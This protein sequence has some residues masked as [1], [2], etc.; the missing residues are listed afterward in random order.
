MTD[1]P[2]N[3]NIQRIKWLLL[4][5]SLVTIVYLVLAA[6][7][8]HLSGAWRQYQMTYR[9]ALV[10][11]ADDAASQRSAED[12]AIGFQQIFLPQLDRID[13]C[14][15]CHIAIDDPKQVDAPQPL[16]AHSGEIL[17][18]HSASKFGCTVCH[19]G[20]GRATEEAAAHGNVAHWSA[21][22]LQGEHVY[23]SCGRCHYENDLFGAEFDF[24]ADHQS[25]PPI[26]EAELEWTV[27]GAS[28]PEEH[29]VGRG[30]QLVI[31]S[32]CLGCHQYRGRGGEVGE[33]ITH[34]GD[35]GVHDF[36]FAH[37]QGE[38]TVEQWLFEH[39]KSPANVSPDTVMPDM[40]FTNQQARDLTFYMMS[41]H[42][43][44]MPATH[45][46]VPPR[47][48]GKPVD[49]AHL[50]AMFCS[51]CHG[52]EGRGVDYFN[53]RNTAVPSLR[54]LAERLSLFD[55]EHTAPAA[56][57]LRKGVDPATRKD[58]PPFDAEMYGE[59][60]TQL[61]VMR[62]VIRNGRPGVKKNPESLLKP[63][64]MPSWRDTLTDRQ[65]DEIIAYL[66]EL[67]PWE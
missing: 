8:E 9:A 37:V 13:R 3:I 63:V 46:P 44:Q 56:D 7:E 47:R 45:T 32:G 58:D 15:T 35:D 57:L 24:Y 2:D 39:F 51:A 17:K 23:T 53:E 49:A 67:Y 50:F 40:G 55:P 4:V 29:A 59:F 26:D 48:R 66:I 36:D 22:L 1:T 30:K 16:R 5:S 65:I 43:K 28:A 33:D 64:N 20:Q 19:D 42:R 12:M 61:E 11:R 31:E 38:R 21:P 41:L 54:Y 14:T 62:D 27:P 6:Y 10:S 60:L 52:R 18:G 34:I 25:L